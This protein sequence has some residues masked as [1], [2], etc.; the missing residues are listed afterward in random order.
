MKKQISCGIICGSTMETDFGY[1][2]DDIGCMQLKMFMKTQ[3]EKLIKKGVEKIYTNCNVG[4]NL[5]CAEIALRT[6]EDKADLICIQPYENQAKK[7]TSDYRDRFFALHEKCTESKLLHINYDLRYLYESENYIVEHSDI[8]VIV[9][10]ATDKYSLAAKYALA[11]GKEIHIVDS[12]TL[13]AT[14][15]K[16]QM[17]NHGNSYLF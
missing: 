8:I 2:E 11:L 14:V 13:S 16:S 10:S 1:D 12:D 15:I 9:K 3:F 4:L 7:W 17:V 6:C 5:I